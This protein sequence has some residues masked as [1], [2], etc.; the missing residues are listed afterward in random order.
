MLIPF[1]NS[2][3]FFSE[4]A[5]FRAWSN[6]A[7]ETYVMLKEEAAMA[8]ANAKI[9][10]IM[11]PL[12]QRNYKPGEYNVT[13]QP[14]T[15]IHLNNAL[16]AGNQPVSN[17]KY[18]YILST[19]AILL[20]VIAC[21]NFVTLSIGRSTTRAL[22]VGVRKVLGAR[23]QQLVRQYWGEAL[24]LSL[25]AL[26]IGLFVSFLLVKPFNQLAGRELSLSIYGFTIVFC[27]LLVIVM[28]LIAG[29]YPALVLS[30][31]KPIQVLKG[32]L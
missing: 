15:D 26:I 12:V 18:S 14:I 7:V 16:P 9:P 13:L 17:P 19:V 3:L 2:S 25:L 11:Q 1:S 27:L 10:A 23:R 22:E 24:L 5:R 21:I 28:G 4:G 29:I 6:V 30:G 31:F 32:R 20:L 8:D